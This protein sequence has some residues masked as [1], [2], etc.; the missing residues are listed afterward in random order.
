MVELDHTLLGNVRRL[1]TGANVHRLKTLIFCYEEAIHAQVAGHPYRP[2]FETL[3][4]EF[5]S[6]ALK[7]QAA[8]RTAAGV[9]SYSRDL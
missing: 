5:V 7:I 6:E 4:R 8:R 1:T 9:L 2:M 3:L